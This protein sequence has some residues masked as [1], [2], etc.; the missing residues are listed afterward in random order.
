M[1][2]FWKN[3]LLVLS[4]LTITLLLP[5]ATANPYIDQIDYPNT[6]VLTGITNITVTYKDM[7][8]TLLDY[9]SC[10]N[11]TNSKTWAPTAFPAATPTITR[12]YAIDPADTTA[13]VVNT[14]YKCDFNIT[15]PTSTVSYDKKTIF[16]Y[17]ANPQKTDV[18]EINPMI[19]LLAALGCLAIVLHPTKTK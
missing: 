15:N 9:V 10:S 2:R 4:I 7:N 16:F 14:Q 19:A 17:T 1:S 13:W 18:P 11:G 12:N 5:T 6:V 8:N 3:N